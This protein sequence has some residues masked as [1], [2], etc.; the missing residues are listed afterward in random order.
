[1][2]LLNLET[3]STFNH[4]SPTVEAVKKYIIKSA[5]TA[6]L[7]HSINRT[8]AELEGNL[9][10][11]LEINRSREEL[12]LMRSALEA[13]ENSDETSS[14]EFDVTWIV[15]RK[16]IVRDSSMGWMALRRPSP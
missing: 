11:D 16:A 6:L 15:A 12:K 1:M 4:P 5:S 8:S 14:W 10:T 3:I 7:G 2:R 9:E 13:I